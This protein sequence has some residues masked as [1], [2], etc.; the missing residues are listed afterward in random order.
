MKIDNTPNWSQTGLNITTEQAYA[1][2]NMLLNM[3]TDRNKGFNGAEQDDSSTRTERER[4]GERERGW[5]MFSS[6]P[7]K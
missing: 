2:D 5:G 3:T 4:D 1:Y 7:P 6:K